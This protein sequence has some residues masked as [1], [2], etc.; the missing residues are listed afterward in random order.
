MNMILIA[1][2]IAL[3]DT[4]FTNKYFLK[5]NSRKT[6]LTLLLFLISFYVA[7]VVLDFLYKFVS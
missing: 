5:N 4:Y 6:I 3:V 1:L 7:S 2:F